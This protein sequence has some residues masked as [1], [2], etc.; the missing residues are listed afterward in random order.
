M[1]ID[2]A[3]EP[4]YP[5]I[6]LRQLDRA[7][8]HDWY[9]YL[10]VPAVTR[11]TSWDLRSAQDLTPIFDAIESTDPQSVRRLA[12]VDARSGKLAGTIGFHTISLRNQSAEIAYDVAPEY[13]G[14]GIATAA[15][16][17]VTEWAFA[18]YGWV[19]VQG[20][21]LTTHPNSARV[22]RKCGFCHE[23]VLRSYRIVRGRPRDFDI[24]ARLADER[25]AAAA[26]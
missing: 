23:G 15:C 2:S 20:T 21:V 3:P 18:E 22:L 19:R 5:G 16:N 26:P 10:R 12:I 4:G 1:R 14:K 7:D 6:S 9:A 17:A 24:Y 25:G 13:W 8:L 11:H